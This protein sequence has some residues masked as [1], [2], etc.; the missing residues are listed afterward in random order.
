MIQNNDIF[1]LILDKSENQIAVFDTSFNRVYCNKLWISFF[2]PEAD[3][4][5]RAKKS[6]LSLFLS[7]QLKE[8][9]ALTLSGK[10]FTKNYPK[11]KTGGDSIVLEVSFTP[12]TFDDK[13]RSYA[14]ISITL[15]KPG[16]SSVTLLPQGTDINTFLNR[17]NIFYLFLDEEC[18]IQ[19]IND[20]GCRILESRKELIIGK[21]W[22]D[23]AI[24]NED[25]QRTRLV[26]NSLIEEN[27]EAYSFMESKINTAYGAIRTIEW[28][29]TVIKNVEG[30]VQGVLSAGTDIT[31][32]LEA[33][34]KLKKSES[35]YRKLSE[36]IMDIFFSIDNDHNVLYWN[37]IS[38]E[39][40]NIPA[41]KT[42]GRDIFDFIDFDSPQTIKNRITKTIESQKSIH[43]VNTINIGTNKKLTFDISL[44]PT[45]EGVSVLARDITAQVH[46]QEQLF[47][48]A[49]ILDQLQ[50]AVITTDT[51]GIIQTVNRPCFQLY[52][53]DFHPLKGTHITTIFQE[54]DKE[55][56]LKLLEDLQ[57]SGEYVSHEFLLDRS[58]KSQLNA[59][60]NVT[61][62]K[63]ITNI[64]N[65]YIITIIDITQTAKI[66]QEIINMNL[67]LEKT[68][69]ERTAELEQAK[70]RAENAN[71][72]K[73]NFLANISHEIM[74]PM[75][76]I[77]GLNHLLSKTQLNEIQSTYTSKITTASQ[78]L[79]NIINDILDYSKLESGTI[80]IQHIH[81]SL[82][83]ILHEIKL[84]IQKLQEVQNKWHIAV[85]FI[86]DS[87][88]PLDL[89]GDPV[90][91]KQ[92]LEILTSNAVKFSN[93]GN[94]TVWVKATP[95]NTDHYLFNF[96]ISDT[97]IGIP[98]KEIKG[99]FTPF[100]QADA[101]K[102]RKFGGTGMGL[103]LCKKIISNLDGKIRVRSVLQEGSTFSVEIPYTS[104]PN[105]LS[106]ESELQSVLLVGADEY[107][108]ESLTQI[109]RRYHVSLISIHKHES[110]AFIFKLH[111]P[112]KYDLLIL[113]S[114]H[115][116]A[117]T[118]LVAKINTIPFKKI[119]IIQ[120]EGQ[121]SNT[122]Q[123]S[124]FTNAKSIHR[125]LL[126][127]QFHNIIV[128]SSGTIITEAS[129]II[130]ED[131]QMSKVLIVEDEEV[132][133]EMI[134]EL[135]TNRNIKSV[136]CSNA[137]DAISILDREH[138]D[139]ILMDIR[140][141]G[142]DGMTASKKIR[143]QKRL[144]TIPII[145]ISGDSNSNDLSRYYDAGM[146]DFIA[147]PFDI[148]QFYA[149]ITKWIDIE[150]Q[151]RSKTSSS[152]NIVIDGINTDS[153]LK[154][155]HSNRDSFLR[156][157]RLFLDNNKQTIDRLKEAHSNNEWSILK[158]IV[159]ALK[160][161]S[162]N[163]SADELHEAASKY[164]AI[165][166]AGEQE[167]KRQEFDEL[168]FQLDKVL[169]AISDYLSMAHDTTQKR[170][171]TTNSTTDGKKVEKEDLST[172]LA[173]IKSSDT[174][175]LTLL[176]HIEKEGLNPMDLLVLKTLK[177]HCIKF[178]FESAL[179]YLT[180]N[181]EKL[182]HET[183]E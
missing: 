82:E 128:N 109:F 92:I 73:T 100:S 158:E 20:A 5:G 77:M 133:R 129:N 177:T 44:Y 35:Q 33:E 53:L 21:N 137:N 85:N 140:M 149:T 125:P 134:A 179:N 127:S 62:K 22:I 138:F 151:N 88:V 45:T 150:G 121:N 89:Q 142:I 163:I 49:Q 157:I 152:E 113:D 70:K 76:A 80:E 183:G 3:L 74:T 102:S 160:G 83:R 164:Q 135:L 90:R 147:K 9:I 87:E 167:N 95:L 170:K 175:A 24:P 28:Q 111:T 75:N 79:L 104:Y 16:T 130:E 66:R 143:S 25:R 110:S 69:K 105:P 39:L 67:N 19:F 26:F 165:L 161:V 43:L 46:F 117:D 119:I 181:W 57:K 86:I 166:D 13:N 114:E 37:K 162:G 112:L 124:Y 172:L 116:R 141:P 38:E 60:V 101:S 52:D 118:K 126:P 176:D 51:E 47:E 32:R 61:H 144:A 96:S 50:E 78:G 115:F 122:K 15:S 64:N 106:N 11:I 146:N 84:Q 145:A 174:R 173:Y 68:V 48:Q 94:I 154:R 139:A 31:D 131:V 23:I 81:F 182:V 41:E 29:N 30:E 1:K 153:A 168:C 156:I 7:N 180:K 34:H 98:Q 178:D 59:L 159:H 103:A 27:S 36:S 2:G 136:Q 107:T 123:S 54:N 14:L 12:L 17:S 72:A 132:N 18:N 42:I 8:D 65:G 58:D 93:E 155:L 10:K 91:L 120:S 108:T 71:Q 97:G 55:R 148:T 171:G 99:L 169:S 4:N 63:T 40:F 56:V 6:E